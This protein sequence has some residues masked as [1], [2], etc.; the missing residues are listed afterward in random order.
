M[1]LVNLL[2][3]LC[4]QV[5]YKRLA[6]TEKSDLDNY[7][8]EAKKQD[9]FDGFSNL[10]DNFKQYQDTLTLDKLVALI[11]ILGYYMIF[12]ALI[13]ICLILLGDSLIQKFNLET[14]YPKFSKF[15]RLRS[16]LSRAHL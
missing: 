2:Y 7:L 11:N 10:I 12:Q 4:Q 15:I 8:V 16:K 3:K 6:N 9:L 13:S 5:E 14:R 1:V